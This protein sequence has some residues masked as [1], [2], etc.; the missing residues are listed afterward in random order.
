MQSRPKGR[1]VGR[2][3]RHTM[4][5]GTVKEYRYDPHQPKRRGVAVGDTL[6]SL[7][8]AFQRSPEWLRLAA[9]TRQNYTLY[10]RTLDRVGHVRAADVKRRD[11]LTIRDSVAASRGNGAAFGF[12]RAVSAL[13]AWGVD[14]E[15]LEHNIAHGCTKGLPR[16]HLRAWTAQEAATAIALLPEHLRRVV[17]LA[18][19]TGQ[20]RGDL[21]SLPWSA[22]DGR[23]IRLTQGKTAEPLVI[24]CHPALKA[25]LDGWTVCR[26]AVTILTDAQ[27][28][29][30]KPN[31]L[32]HYLPAALVRIGLSNELNIHGLRKLA[33]TNLAEAGCSAHEIA[34]VTGHRTLA[35]VA[36]YTRSVD[37]ERL[38]SA[39]IVRLSE[40]KYKP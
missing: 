1:K 40:R 9:D 3:V 28:K 27:G 38:A 26:T 11:L 8:A 25:E 21:C 16:G 30:W 36:L 24:P 15:W 18:L 34:S 22:Y 6:A 37:Q 2:V 20:R 4:A 33:A 17:V 12:V 14:R 5:D 23:A 19:Y 35:M 39:A 10:L 32:S 29:P 13:F 31:L 7:I